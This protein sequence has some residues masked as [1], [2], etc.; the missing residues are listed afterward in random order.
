M[1]MIFFVWEEI[2]TSFL[3]EDNFDKIF[4][5]V[6]TKNTAHNDGIISQIGKRCSGLL[7]GITDIKVKN[8]K[9]DIKRGS[10][11]FWKFL[12][13]INVSA[14]VGIAITIKKW[15]LGSPNK[16]NKNT[17]NKEV[18]DNTRMLILSNLN[19]IR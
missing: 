13:L 1:I 17:D 3:L 19:F 8:I 16:N 4:G 7:N 18:L 2:E 5:M 9:I 14:M 10:K 15:M 6:L 11:F 12:I